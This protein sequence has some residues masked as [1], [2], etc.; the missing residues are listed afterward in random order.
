V[1]H[2]L[3]FLALAVSLSNVQVATA[4]SYPSR[5]ITLIVPAAVGGPTDTI[6]RILTSR[7]SAT[8][9]QTIVLEDNGAAGG[10]VA[11]GKA[12]RAEPDGYTLSIG[13]VG[14]HVFNGAIYTLPY[15]LRSAFDPVA[16]IA[17]NPQLIDGKK[18]LAAN[19]L[20]ELIAWMK[21]NPDVALQGTGGAG[22]PAH[23]SG[24][25]LQRETGTKFVFVPYNGGGPA[26]QALLSGQVDILID[27]AAN[28][29]PQ[30]QA[31]RIK[32]FAVTAKTRLAGAPDIPT[33]D[34]AGLPGFYT[35]IWHGLWAPKGTP[36]PI[37]A[38][39]NAAVVD[40]LADPAVRQR[41]AQLGQEL[42]PRDQ[43]TPEALGA[44]QR[45]EIDKWWPIIKAANIKID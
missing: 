40:A 1:K 32:A 28:S 37:I 45:S 6:A 41:L 36:H 29:L 30:L 7:M 20:K 14:T 33:V 19:T 23:I 38:R 44:L 10:S 22:S 12:A 2:R 35:A 3:A 16:E 13:H 25:Y 24:V 18:S 42:P 34:E 4:E 39:L 15:D 8:L 11:V 21:A 9:G 17:T 5:P 26:M 27:Q 43:Q 31:G